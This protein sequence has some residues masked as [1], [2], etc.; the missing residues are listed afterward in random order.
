MAWRPRRRSQTPST[1]RQLGSLVDFHTGFFTG[2]FKTWDHTFVVLAIVFCLLG[3]ILNVFPLSFM[4]N[5]VRKQKIPWK[6]Q[7][8]IW[9]AGLRGAIAFALSQNM[10][11]PHKDVY[12][13]T[14]LSIVIFTTV[15]CGGLT[16]PMLRHAGMKRGT[17]AVSDGDDDLHTELLE[18]GQEAPQPQRRLSIPAPGLHAAFRELDQRYLK[19][20]FGGQMMPGSDSV[21]HRA[22]L[23]RPGAGVNGD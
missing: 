11:G 2:R 17:D 19:P 14:T 22:P 12:E 6:M 4:C 16:E 15:V 20:L 5:L 3:R 7:V 18:V 21:P 1:R 8:V 10:P 23:R 9:F 13:T